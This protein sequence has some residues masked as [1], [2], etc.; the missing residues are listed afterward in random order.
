[1]YL[2]LM[3]IGYYVY[4]C[5]STPIYEYVHAAFT[6]SV[7]V[8]MMGLIAEQV[9]DAFEEGGTRL[10][11]LRIVFFGTYILSDAYP[12]NQVLYAGY[13]AAGQVWSVGQSVGWFLSSAPCGL[14][15][16]VSPRPARRGFTPN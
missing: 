10:M 14:G 6:T 12:V 5:Y 8:F 16:V 1:M 2:F 11:G 4:V 7:M 15:P 9:A 13:R 3:G